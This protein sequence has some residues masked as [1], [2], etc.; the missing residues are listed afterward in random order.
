MANHPDWVKKYQEKGTQAVKIKEN[1][2]LYKITSVWDPKKGRARK[3]TEKYLGKITPDGIVKPKQERIIEGLNNI[4]V[5]EFGASYFINSIASNIIE[6]LKENYPALWK[7]IFVFSTMRL[8]HSSPLKNVSHYYNSSHLSDVFP[9]AKVSPKSLSEWLFSVGKERGKMVDFMKNFVEG[10]EFLVIDLT[11]IFS[12]SENIISA[13]TG[14]NSEEDYTPQINLVLLYSLDKL[15]PSFFR[16]VP[17]SIRDV[18]V[19][20][21]SLKEAGVKKAVIIG[22]KGFF[23]DDN[24]KFLETEELDYILPLKRNSSLIDYSPIQ[25]GDKK[26]FDGHFLFEKRVIWYYE[27]EKNNRRIIVFLDE[28]LKAE[29]EKDFITHVDNKKKPMD[30]YFDRQFKIGTI[31]VIAKTSFNADEVFE[32]LKARVEIESLFDTFKNLLHADRSYMRDEAHLQGWMF[33]NFVSLL[34]YYKIYELLI[35]KDLLANCSPKDV[36]LHLSRI[37]K[38]KIEG[39]WI[40]SEIPK[41]SRKIIEKLDFTV[42]IT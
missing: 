17:G 14:H 13:T 4:T 40:L 27:R 34:L 16:L 11:H 5:K 25:S 35:N 15:Q 19:I 33:V 8:F 1:Y 24:I 42:H 2:Y 23:S 38:L 3:V 18:S 9:D 41:K 6:L 28:K 26:S 22:D 10:S 21:V 7:E 39:K 31:A 37:Y 12:L 20:P 30:D 29:E 32:Y 36:I